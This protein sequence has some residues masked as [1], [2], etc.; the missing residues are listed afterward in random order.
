MED[1]I[2][3]QSTETHK[4]MGQLLEA[5]RSLDGLLSSVADVYNDVIMQNEEI[6]AG[7][8]TIRDKL[9]EERGLEDTLIQEE[10]TCDATFVTQNASLSGELSTDL[11]ELMAISN[12]DI[13][14]GRSAV[15]LT[16]NAGYQTYSA[17][18]ELAEQTSS[19]FAQV[20]QTACNTMTSFMERMGRKHG[21]KMHKRR[22]PTCEEQFTNLQSTYETTF[23]DLINEY[24]TRNQSVYLNHS[25]CMDTAMYSYR[26]AVEGTDGID[27][28]IEKAANRIHDA[29]EQI[30]H[31]GSRM[32]D[33]EHAVTRMRTH[34]T[35]LNQ[36]CTVD[37]TVDSHLV[38][39]KN[40]IG[41]LQECPGRN[42]FT[43]TVP[44]W[45]HTYVPGSLTHAPTPTPTPW[46]DRFSSDDTI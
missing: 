2:S 7:N 23:T 37:E 14:G 34:I 35:T 5:K 10:S 18:S 45:V 21:G 26:L 29:Q 25:Q 41:Q 39:L 13:W 8:A 6:E 16:A 11:D 40:L 24:T 31:Y 20:D 42:N 36:T 22:A 27:D 43:L 3:R 30:S 19:S 32:H 33:V 4:C 28:Q 44:T 15:S 9:A 46:Q 17:F 38:T 12:P 1:L